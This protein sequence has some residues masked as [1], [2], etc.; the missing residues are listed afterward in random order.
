MNGNLF[1]VLRGVRDRALGRLKK[2][3]NDRTPR[4]RVRIVVVAFVLFA[5]L[6]VWMLTRIFRGGSEAPRIE[7]IEALQPLKP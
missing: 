5:V 1:G 4:Q 3:L 7:H 6:D 2:Y